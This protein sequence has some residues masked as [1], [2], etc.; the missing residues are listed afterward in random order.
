MV[1]ASATNIWSSRGGGFQRGGRG[2]WLGCYKNFY[3]TNLGSLL[4]DDT[5][6]FFLHWS[7]KKFKYGKCRLGESTLTQ[8][9]LDTPNL[10]QIDFFVL[11]GGGPMKK[12]TLYH[13][14]YKI[15]CFLGYLAFSLSMR[16][17]KLSSSPCWNLQVKY[18]NTQEIRKKTDY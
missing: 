6:C 10:A 8:I 12:N 4:L 11:I 13:V 2:G 16:S 9:L 17:S 18:P 5:G 14:C 1:Q 3:V 7:P 15:I